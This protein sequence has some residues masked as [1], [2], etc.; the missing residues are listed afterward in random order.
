[1]KTFV[2]I[3]SVFLILSFIPLDN[4]FSEIQTDFQNLDEN[5][6]SNLFQITLIDSISSFEPQFSE[7]ANES[8]LVKVQLHESLGISHPF[9]EYDTVLKIKHLLPCG[10]EIF[11]LGLR[12]AFSQKP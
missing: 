4:S 7:S 6:K 3:L 9:N 2:I 1:M 5:K 11:I 10:G 12:M 8:K